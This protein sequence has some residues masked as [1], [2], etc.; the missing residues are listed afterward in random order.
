ME[1]PGEFSFKEKR[2]KNSKDFWILICTFLRDK[3]GGS[4]IG[5]RLWNLTRW[6]FLGG[7]RKSWFEA[8]LKMV[9][10]ILGEVYALR[11]GSKIGG[12]YNAFS[13]GGSNL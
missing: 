6:I 10:K 1:K 5:F 3:R 2:P 4:G 8:H 13:R 11:L 9:F 12:P 7:K